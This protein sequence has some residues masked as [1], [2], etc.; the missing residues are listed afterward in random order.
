MLCYLWVLVGSA[1]HNE[2]NTLKECNTSW[3]SIDSQDSVRKAYNGRGDWRDE[4]CVINFLGTSIYAHLKWNMQYFCQFLFSRV[5][6][7]RVQFSPYFN[8]PRLDPR[9]KSLY[10]IFI[11]VQTMFFFK[12]TYPSLYILIKFTL[13]INSHFWLKSHFNRALHGWRHRCT[14]NASWSRSLDTVLLK[15]FV[16][17]VNSSLLVAVILFL[18]VP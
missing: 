1:I 15:F 7:S 14:R 2:R 12:D 3:I 18:N 9:E 4:Q 11:M 17:C 6:F 16:Y 5:Q 13:I 10:S 8:F